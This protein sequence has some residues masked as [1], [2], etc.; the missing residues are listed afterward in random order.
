M[1]Q[2]TDEQR[3]RWPKGDFEAIQ[4]LKDAGWAL[5]KDWTWKPPDSLVRQLDA[6]DFL[7]NEW[8]FG[9]WHMDKDQPYGPYWVEKESL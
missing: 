4:V 7:V 5:R 2:T 6:I 3:S 1:P 9:G 8:D